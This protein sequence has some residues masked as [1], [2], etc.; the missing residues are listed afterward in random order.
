MCG[1]VGADRRAQHRAGADRRACGASSTAATTRP[2]SRCSTPAARWRACARSARCSVLQDALDGCA[3]GRQPRHRAH[4]L[5]HA[6]R[7]ERAQRA[8]AHLARRPRASCTTASSRTTRS[9][10]HELQRARLRVHLR[11]RHRGHR[12]PHP[13]PPADARRPVQGGARH[14]RG[15]RG[16]LRAGGDQPGGAGPHHRRAHGLPG[17]DRPRRRRELRRLR[18]RRA[19]AG[20]AALHVPRGRRRRRGRARRRARARSRGQP[21]ERAGAARASCRPTPPRRASTGTSC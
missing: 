13:L 1:I 9:C 7:A 15:A 17:G 20:H 16:R 21:V 3:H 12:A 5:G 14:G 6:R 18:R 2:A 19:A 11:D 8:S 10:A 4:A